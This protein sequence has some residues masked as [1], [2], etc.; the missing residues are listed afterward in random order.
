MFVWNRAKL[1]STGV[2]A[3]SF[4]LGFVAHGQGSHQRWIATWGTAELQPYGDEALPKTTFDHTTLRQVVH[5]SCGGS[6]LRIRLSNVFGRAPLEISSVHIAPALSKG[7]IAPGSSK[8][9][10]FSGRPSVSV[11]MGAEYLSDAINFPVAPL[12]DIA[13]DIEIESAPVDVT[14]HTGAHAT[15]YLVAGN[16]GGEAQ[17]STPRTLTRWYFLSGLE[18]V[19]ASSK[20]STIV[21]FGDSITDGHA[22]TTDGND[23]WPDFLARRLA[24]N[25]RTR[26]L[27]VVNA[28]IGGNHFLYDGLGPNAL[29]RFDRD[30]LARPSTRYLLIL[31]G[32]NDLGGLDRVQEHG[33][34]AHAAW[35]AQVKAAFTQMVMRA[36]ATGIVVY[37]ATLTPYV[38]SDYYHPNAASELDRTMLN[39]WI[40]K[41]GTFDGVIDFDAAVRDPAHP[42]HMLP[43]ADSGDHLHPGPKGYQRMGD[44]I[45]LQ[46][47]ER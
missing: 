32:I 21:A 10:T 1:Y 31:E 14:L 13:V 4:F 33:A 15:S 45:P 37:A 46:L 5:V 6:T 44:A 40:R 2:L 25:P 39:D 3:L 47:F 23:R 9:L 7:T 35:L 30:V 8:E 19:A 38:G 16:H 26:D 43:E 28:G 18:V 20:A 24:T 41:S 12:S 34:E 22:S 36:H 42:D 17:M 27:G 11:P 29:A